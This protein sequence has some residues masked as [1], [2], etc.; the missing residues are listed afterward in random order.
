MSEVDPF[1]TQRGPAPGFPGE[2]HA[3]GFED[4]QEIGRGGFGIVYRCVQPSLDRT[5]AVKVLTS[6]LDPDNLERFLREQRAMGRLSGHPNIV[7]ILQ[8][9]TTGSGHPYLVMQLHSRGSL[10]SLIRSEGPLD[11]Q[12]VLHLGVKLCGALEVAHRTGIVH[13]DVKPANVLLTDY[14]EPQLT[15]FGIARIP[16]GFETTVAR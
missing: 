11:W 6:D 2:L 12:S 1:R 10:E 7:T 16:G 4:A 5:V 3:D 8:V 14:G 13:R 15:D 9:G